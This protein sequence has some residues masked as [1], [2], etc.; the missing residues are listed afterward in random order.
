[1]ATRQTKFD[2][3]I[4]LPVDRGLKRRIKKIAEAEERSPTEMARLI[5]REGVERHEQE[6]AKAPAVSTVAA[7]EA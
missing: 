6:H 1:M 3:Y 5:L 4:G 2:D 7:S